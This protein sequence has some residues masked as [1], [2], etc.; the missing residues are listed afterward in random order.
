MLPFP[1]LVER[2][3]LKIVKRGSY[4]QYD[5]AYIQKLFHQ[6]IS[7]D[8][9]NHD[10]IGTGDQL[11]HVYDIANI[12]YQEFETDT[13]SL[14][15]DLF[16]DNPL[17]FFLKLENIVSKENVDKIED[18]IVELKS[19]WKDSEIKPVKIRYKSASKGGKVF[20]LVIYPIC[21][22][23]NKRIIYLAG[24]G[25]SPHNQQGLDYN[26]YR[27]DRFLP[28]SDGKK[29]YYQ[30]LEWNDNS[31]DIVQKLSK[32]KDE[33]LKWNSEH[34]YKQLSQALG[35]DIHRQIKTMLLRFPEEFHKGYIEGS[36]RH[37]TFKRLEFQNIN[38][39]L[40]E[41]KRIVEVEIRPEEEELIR[42]IVT[43]HPQDAYYTMRYRHGQ[44]G[45]YDVEFDVVMRLRAWGHN[46]EILHPA[47]LRQRM[48][49]DYE[50]AWN[51]YHCLN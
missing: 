46:A 15:S 31:S 19:I 28:L 30:S 50:R 5:E 37:E 12:L 7:N 29:Q 20:A 1:I 39:F 33:L 35:V 26:I 48:K 23:Y 22:F 2:G 11:S 43:K 9:S 4:V 27:L 16:K 10:N 14:I 45:G 47:D 34:I 42:K 36:K 3:F 8:S 44:E 17:R 41:F 21:A 6:L 18:V 51:I 13:L 49:E 40:T 32:E 38:Q 25:S 24:Y